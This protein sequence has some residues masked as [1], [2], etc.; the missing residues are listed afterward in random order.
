MNLILKL[1]LILKQAGVNLV[2]KN[3]QIKNTVF[4]IKRFKLKNEMIN[5]HKQIL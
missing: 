4:K 3:I 5:V 2:M 1:L